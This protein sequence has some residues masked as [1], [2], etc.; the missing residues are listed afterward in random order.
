MTQQTQVSR[1]VPYYERFL[2]AFPTIDDLAAA[3]LGDVL[4]VWSG[5]GYNRRARHL[6]AAAGHIV[7][8]GWPRT[9]AAL[10]QLPGIG[11]Y[12]A[13]AVACFAFGEPIAAVDTNLRRVL[14]RWHGVTLSG[15]AL[16]DAASAEIDGG[17]PTEWN[18]A[19]MD[20]GAT[21]CVPQNPRC[22]ACPVTA[23]CTDPSTYKPP[24]KQSTFEGSMRQARGA[25]LKTLVAKGP[26]TIATIA[27]GAAVDEQRIHDAAAALHSEG[28]I[29]RIDDGWSLAGR[30][31]SAA[32]TD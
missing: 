32:G 23:W 25:V 19:V 14:S 2:A 20:L 7:A 16:T 6:H 18:Q 22:D 3:A 11:P 15:R 5:L 8:A 26:T 31:E 9:A 24:P 29:E 30:G 10:Q 4:A 1:V 12:T 28:M 21:V 13:S 27:A 17:R